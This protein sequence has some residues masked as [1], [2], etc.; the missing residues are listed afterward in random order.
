MGGT[1]F[2]K[3]QRGPRAGT[4]GDK[5]PPSFDRFF[6]PTSMPEWAAGELLEHIALSRPICAGDLESSARCLVAD[7][8]LRS[9]LAVPL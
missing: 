9:T 5:F 8:S 6:R 2:A 3:L 7:A 1:A 4:R